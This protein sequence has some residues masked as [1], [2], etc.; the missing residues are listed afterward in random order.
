MQETTWPAKP[1][2]FMIWPPLLWIDLVVTSVTLLI[3]GANR[4]DLAEKG[5]APVPD[6]FM[7][8]LAETVCSENVFSRE[9][10]FSQGCLSHPSLVIISKQPPRST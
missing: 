5:G 1:K 8:I 7:G 6:S 10:F 3:I 4:P 9:L 2:I